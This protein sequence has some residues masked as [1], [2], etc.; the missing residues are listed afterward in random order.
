[1]NMKIH[2]DP[3]FKSLIPPLSGDEI[4][5][6]EK[7]LLA[8]GCR[9][10]IVI[11]NDTIID[12]HHRYAICTRH[13]LHFQT[14]AMDFVDNDAVKIWIIQNQFGRRNLALFTRSELALKLEPLIAAKAKENQIARKGGQ[15]GT[16]P[17]NSAELFPVETRVEVAKVAGVS[18]DTIE[19]AKL[20]SK[21]A[22][23]DTKKQLRE[24][25]VSI[26][27]VAK[28]IKEK[29]AKEK[30]Q[31]KRIEAAADAPEDE[32]I[33]L[34]DFR[35]VGRQ[36][37][38]GSVSLIFTDPPYD[39]ESTKLFP[40]LAEFANRV[41]ADGGSILF[42]CGHL[43]LPY[44]WESFKPLRYWWQCACVH[45]G[46]HQL[47]REYGIR[48]GW[49]PLLWFVKGTRDDI[50]NIVQDTFSGG[51]EKDH[52]DWQQSLAE[53][54]LWIKNLCPSDGLVCDPFLGGGTTAVAA[55]KLGRKWFGIEVDE[56]TAKI[57][58]KRIYDQ[59]V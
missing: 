4:A 39:R 18:H 40:A 22:D 10:P 45:A 52:H 59:T 42:Y 55:Q 8:E 9:D 26:H 13:S 38:S 57:A 17:Q 49:K 27:R 29:L 43:Q 58:A 48:V 44:V 30:R 41:L 56:P 53:A 21:H 12:G 51:Q 1:M 5:Q 36:I 23:E 15:H 2:I 28:D 31:E 34:G 24:N 3:E 33:I 11:W 14:H 20:I 35:V 7:N 54:E 25:K 47:M 19:K 46:Q 6:L 32:R 37:P 16:S 50:S